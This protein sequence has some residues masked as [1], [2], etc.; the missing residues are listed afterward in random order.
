MCACVC[1]VYTVHVSVYLS[2]VCMFVCVT[3]NVQCVCMYVCVCVCACMYVL[4]MCMRLLYNTNRFINTVINV[5][6]TCT[7]IL[8]T[9]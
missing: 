3:Y 6:H 7:H 1:T 9:N 4:Y 2:C 8:L 5:A